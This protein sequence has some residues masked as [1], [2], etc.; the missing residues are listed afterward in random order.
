MKT[1]SSSNRLVSSTDEKKHSVRLKDDNSRRWRRR[2][3]DK[4]RA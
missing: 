2:H 3:N 1:D 4:S